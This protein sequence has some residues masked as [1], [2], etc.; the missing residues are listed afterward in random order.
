MYQNYDFYLYC[1][2]IKKVIDMQNKMIGE[3]EKEIQLLKTEVEALRKIK[4]FTIEKIEYKFDQ[5]KVETLSGTLNIGISSGG[6]GLIDE[7][8]VEGEN[9]DDLTFPK[10]KLH[11]DMYKNIIEEVDKYLNNGILDELKILE[12]RYNK[13]IDSNRRELI[14]NDIRKQIEKQINLYVEQNKNKMSSENVRA[15]EDDTIKKMIKDINQALESFIKYYP[16]ET[17]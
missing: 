7:L 17:N 12:G 16:K 11:I 6:T 4:P 3:L 13:T 2:K 15:F 5:L 9:K 10:T 8:S 14:I 1:Q